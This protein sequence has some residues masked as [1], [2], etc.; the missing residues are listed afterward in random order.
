MSRDACW[1]LSSWKKLDQEW[2]TIC[3]RGQQQ[4]V[5]VADSVQRTTYQIGEHWGTMADC[6]HLQDHATSRLWDLAH[7]CSKRLQDDVDSLADIYARMRRLLT[8]G[9]ASAL[10][11]ERRQRYEQSLLEVLA[12]YERELVAKSLIASDM[13]ECSKHETMTVYLASWQMQPHIDRLRLEEIE[14]LVQNDSHYLLR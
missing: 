13:F 10:G 12:M 8:D 7:R 14:T 2:K 11:E 9:Q 3:V 1:W 4:L 6:V 5:K